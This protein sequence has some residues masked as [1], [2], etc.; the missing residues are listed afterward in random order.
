MSFLKYVVFI[1][2]GERAVPCI[3]TRER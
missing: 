2:K 1:G 3:E